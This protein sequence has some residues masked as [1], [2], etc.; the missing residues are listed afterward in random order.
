[1]IKMRGGPKSLSFEL[2]YIRTHFYTPK[3]A[4]IWAIRAA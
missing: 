1:M 3:I 2:P 4:S